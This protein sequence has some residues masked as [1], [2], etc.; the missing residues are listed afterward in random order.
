LPLL[1]TRPGDVEKVLL[2]FS[3]AP[4]HRKDLLIFEK[5]KNQERDIVRPD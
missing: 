5:P 4:N 1:I 3:T 2:T